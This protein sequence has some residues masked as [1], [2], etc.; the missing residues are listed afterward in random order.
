MAYDLNDMDL[1]GQAA[2][3]F[4]HHKFRDVFLI[5]LGFLLQLVLVCCRYSHASKE[6]DAKQECLLCYM[7][8]SCNLLCYFI[9]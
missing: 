4:K 2:F 7:K 1:Q 6:N 9:L 5:E 8:T 3:D